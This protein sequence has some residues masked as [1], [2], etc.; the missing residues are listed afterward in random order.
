MR[1]GASQAGWSRV[2]AGVVQRLVSM[3]ELHL[4]SV[5]RTGK[6]PEYI[7]EDTLTTS[8]FMTVDSFMLSFLVSYVAPVP[9]PI[10]ET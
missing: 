4:E 10:P 8:F 7:W 5:L 1:F 9:F 2:E 6:Y 3:Q